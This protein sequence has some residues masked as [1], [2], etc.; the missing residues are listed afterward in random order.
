MSG[1]VVGLCPQPDEDIM[2]AGFETET[3]GSVVKG[4][5]Q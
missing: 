5:Y 3:C 1:G 4:V 2:S